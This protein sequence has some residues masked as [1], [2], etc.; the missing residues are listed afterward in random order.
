MYVT[1]RKS[2]R[3]I[4]LSY[5]N[6]N[7]HITLNNVEKRTVNL[8]QT[9]NVYL[10]GFIGAPISPVLLPVRMTPSDRKKLAALAVSPMSTSEVMACALCFF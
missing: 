1:N 3:K 8:R 10:N 2:V 7:L 5:L 9:C 6:K 4:I